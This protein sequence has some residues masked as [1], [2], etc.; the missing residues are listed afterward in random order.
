MMVKIVDARERSIGKFKKFHTMNLTKALYE[1]ALRTHYLVPMR[2]QKNLSLGSVVMQGFSL[3]GEMKV[4]LTVNGSLQYQEDFCEEVEIGL[5][6]L[7][8]IQ[9]ET[10]QM[11]T[12]MTEL[13]KQIK[14]L[15]G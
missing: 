2:I 3:N 8:E 14:K 5:V 13:R 7:Y 9:E 1:T 10:V 12:W 15:S 6:F 11:R 4:A